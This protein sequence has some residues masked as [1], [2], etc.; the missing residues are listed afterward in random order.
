MRISGLATYWDT[1]APSAGSWV[2]TG[3]DSATYVELTFQ[4]AAVPE[5]STYALGLIGLASFGIVAW[6]RRRPA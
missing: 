5:P 2:Q 3:T 4:A 1:V 6:R